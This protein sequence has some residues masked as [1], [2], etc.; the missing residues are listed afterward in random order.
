MTRDREALR[1]A[2]R[3]YLVVGG[4][5]EAALLALVGAAL[6]GGV[7]CV[8]LRE[9]NL[10]TRAF[11]AR[12]RALRALLRDAGVPLII[13]DRLDVALAAD[14]DGVHVGQDDVD[15]DVVRRHMP[16]AIVGLSVGSLAELDAGIQQRVDYLSPSPLFATRSKPDAG[17][18][19]GLPGLR[20]MR[21][22]CA[23]PL[24]AIGG[25][26][27]GNAAAVFAAG[28]DGIAVVSAIA[29]AVDPRAAAAELA[30]IADVT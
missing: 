28:A 27:R 25:I 15:V 11:V 13:N 17:A 20:E 19:L 24:V 9:K 30:A 21:A 3:L 1:R 12:A 2:L 8:Q 5:D 4:L 29:G 26:D 23:L 7:G 16:H 22:R 18:P 6:R 14:A 10:A